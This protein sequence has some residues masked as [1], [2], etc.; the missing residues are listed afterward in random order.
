VGI[1]ALRIRLAV[2][3]LA[4]RIVA[5]ER[6]KRVNRLPILGLAML[7]AVLLERLAGAPYRV[8]QQDI[9]LVQIAQM[10]DVASQDMPATL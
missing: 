7:D 3:L 8:A 5:A 4:D 10:G 9:L 6:E 1:N 2:H